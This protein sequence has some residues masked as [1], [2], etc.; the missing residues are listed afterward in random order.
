MRLC[1]INKW[2]RRVG[3]VLVFAEDLYGDEHE[4]FV[5]RAKT[6]DARWAMPA[7][8]RAATVWLDKIPKMREWLGERAVEDLTAAGILKPK[9]PP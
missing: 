5:E 9:D 6:Y 2:L 1:T 7:P 8:T 4:I 3:L